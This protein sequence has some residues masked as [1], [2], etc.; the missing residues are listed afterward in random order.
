MGYA[1]SSA[2]I[3]GPLAYI[4]FAFHESGR[5]GY[6]G[7]PNDFMQ[8]SSFGVMPVIFGVY[9]AM[10]FTSLVVGML[11]GLR[12]ATP[13][14]QVV[15][16]AVAT[17]LVSI[18]LF[19]LSLTP[20]WRL[21]FGVTGFIAFISAMLLNP[22][23]ADIGNESAKPE[24][25]PEA[26]STRHFSLLKRY[27]LIFSGIVIVPLAFSQLGVKAAAAQEYYWVSGNEIVL[28]FYGDLALMGAVRG[29]E[30]G[31]MFRFAELKS[32]ETPLSWQRVGPLAAAPAWRSAP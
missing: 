11:Y 13:S 5:L 15:L 4:F 9:P 3:L 32:L 7:A 17:T 2:A 22:T 19:Y 24:P 18:G 27:A 26:A 16:I 10:F 29:R 21:V 14:H 20:V 25:L 28:G 23:A 31:P 1:L 8:I 12:Y 6:F 30:V